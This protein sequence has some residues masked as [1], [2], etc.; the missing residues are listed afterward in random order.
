VAGFGSKR[1]VVLVMGGSHGLGPMEQVVG[2]LRRL[3][4]NVQ[5]IV[6]CGAT[7]GSSKTFIKGS[8]KTRPSGSSA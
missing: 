4:G 1:P 5:V 3:P 2:A 8:T 6:V 7:A